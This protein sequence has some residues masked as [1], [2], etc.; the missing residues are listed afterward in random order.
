MPVVPCSYCGSCVGV[1]VCV[2]AVVFQGAHSI[3]TREGIH[4]EF[5]KTDQHRR[6]CTAAHK[7]SI[8][9][10]HCEFS[11]ERGPNM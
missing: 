8:I 4:K 11:S 6:P 3:Y 5:L 7:R 1:N 10:F 9:I 2:G